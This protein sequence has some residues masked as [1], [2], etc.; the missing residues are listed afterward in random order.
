MAFVEVDSSFQQLYSGPVYEHSHLELG[1]Q[2][3]AQGFLVTALFHRA[4]MLHLH[5][6]FSSRELAPA[7]RPDGR[8]PPLL[9]FA[10]GTDDASFPSSPGRS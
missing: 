3:L 1:G 6:S 8:N 4:R 9:T 10:S 2:Q 7:P 5:A